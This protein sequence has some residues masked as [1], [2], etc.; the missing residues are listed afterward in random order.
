MKLLSASPFY[1]I[2]LSFV[3]LF[4]AQSQS[5][6]SLEGSFEQESSEY[7]TSNQEASGQ[8]VSS[9]EPPSQAPKQNEVQENTGDNPA[10]I[11]LKQLSIALRNLNFSTSFVVVK[12][13]QAE[14]YHWL[15]GLGDENIELTILARLNGP[16][17]DILQKGDIV[18]YIEPEYAPYSVYAKNIKGPIPSIFS[19]DINS[20]SD[21][22]HFVLVGKSRVLGRPAQLIR[23]VPK[24]ENRLGYWLWLDLNSNLLLKLAILS[25][26]G[27]M[28]EQI[29]F[30]HLDI[31]EKLSGNL[32]K[33]QES[34]LPALISLEKENNTKEED[35]DQNKP[36]LDWQVN[37]L[38]EGFKLVSTDTSFL[39]NTKK[40]VYSKLYSDG[41]VDVSVYLGPALKEQ[42]PLGY[43]HDGATVVL[44]KVFNQVEVSV[45]GKVP[46]NTALKIADSVSLR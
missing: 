32:V 28:L 46:A 42:Q 39:G 15:H 37:W 26:K 21:N 10:S 45:V 40:L 34:Q 29:Q 33:L 24:D 22:Y 25:E 2:F 36:K 16:R 41:L 5:N 11:G 44:T 23:I 14:P 1:L 18:S 3:I 31:T 6:T 7:L 19:G 35:S 27:Q 12:N 43:V 30:T 9:Q 38:P 20:L 13:N 4:P 17:R 8:E